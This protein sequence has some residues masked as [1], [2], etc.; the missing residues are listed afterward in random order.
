M[1]QFLG[2][3]IAAGFSM[4]LVLELTVLFAYAD[5]G[6]DVACLRGLAIALILAAVCV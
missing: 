4:Q 5:V 1:I 3:K 6:V 2:A